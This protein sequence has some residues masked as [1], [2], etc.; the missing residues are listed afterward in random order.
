MLAKLFQEIEA[1]LARC[2]GWCELEKANALAAMVLALRPKIVIEI[3]VYGGRSLQAFALPM[4]HLQYGC[5]IGIDPWSNQAS[6]ADMADQ[7]NIEFWA[8]L[9]HERIYQRCLN[10]IS[11]SDLGPYAKIIR[12]KSD[13]VDP[14][15]WEIDLLHVDGSHEETAYRDIVRYGARVRQG[16]I[17][18]CDDT[19]WSSGAPARGVDWLLANGFI[20]LYPL[21]TGAVYQRVR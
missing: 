6:L 14:S 5:V 10:N 7:K 21:G 15:W 19:G 4:K 11:L 8:S 9:D 2:D 17:C 13:D 20:H 1:M 16:G 3:G 12:Q 18:V